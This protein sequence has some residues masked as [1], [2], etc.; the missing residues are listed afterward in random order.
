MSEY[1]HKEIEQKWQAYWE[2]EKTFCVDNPRSSADDSSG[3]K[4]YCMDM[5]P[6]PS[7]DGLHIGHPLGYTATDI[8]SR[9]YRMKGYNVLHPMGFDAFGLPTEQHA[10][11]VGE[12]PAEVAK[13]NCGVFRNQLK[14]LGYSYDWDR[15]VQTCDPKYYKWTQW[16]FLQIYNSWYDSDQSKARPI[17]ELPIPDD[18]KAQGHRAVED[19]RAEH[20]LAYLSE[21]LVNWCPELGSVLANEEVINGCLSEVAFQFS[22]S[23]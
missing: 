2:R 18:V 5:F 20:R 17:S 8:F 4:F 3:Q 21:E 22:K 14:A 10:V 7:G 9:Y 13:K 6:Y 1:N 11:R 23:L 19:Y 12:P 16:I 15:E